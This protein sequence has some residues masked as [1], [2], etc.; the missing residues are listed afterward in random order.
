MRKKVHLT[1]QVRRAIFDPPGPLIPPLLP[2]AFDDS[3]PVEMG[4]NKKAAGGYD[5]IT[6]LIEADQSFNLELQQG[7]D[8]ATFGYREVFS[9]AIDP[10]GTAQIVRVR[11]PVFGDYVRAIVTN[12]GGAPMLFYNRALYGQPVAQHL[13]GFYEDHPLNIR[14]DVTQEANDGINTQI[15]TAAGA[16]QQLLALNTRR[17]NF[18][19][20]NNRGGV[21]Y[22]RP[23]TP[24]QAAPAVVGDLPVKPGAFKV[25]DYLAGFE[26]RVIDSGV[27]ADLRILEAIR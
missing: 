19:I 1:D 15:V 20:E 3:G 24:S 10:S 7:A 21:A 5:M 25:I 11:W 2:A 22:I 6:G 18:F 27:P 9:S 4:G 17:M 13:P 16:E 12:T 8:S 23:V 26:W 14:V